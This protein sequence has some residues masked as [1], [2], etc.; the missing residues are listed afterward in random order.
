MLLHDIVNYITKI[1]PDPTYIK[2]NWNKRFSCGTFT[3]INC[4][5]IVFKLLFYYR[6]ANL[7]ELERYFRT[8]LLGYPLCSSWLVFVGIRHRLS[9]D[10]EMCIVPDMIRTTV[11]LH[12]SVDVGWWYVCIL[13]RAWVGP[14]SLFLSFC[15]PGTIEIY[16]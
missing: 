14:S 5:E 9:I 16:V 1:F 8:F 15:D 3:F 6:E 10:I 7:N 11:V 2:I 4:T 12:F 13:Y